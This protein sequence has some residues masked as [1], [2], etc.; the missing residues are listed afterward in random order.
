MPFHVFL[1]HSSAD[2]PAV[3][4]LARRFAKEGIQAWLDK[5]HLIPGNPWQ[6]DIEKALAE[7]ETCVVLVGPRGFG[8][9]QTRRCVRRSIAAFATAARSG[10]GCLPKTIYVPIVVSSAS[11]NATFIIARFADAR[12]GDS[13]FAHKAGL[14]PDPTRAQR[15]CLSVLHDFGWQLPM[16][17]L[18]LILVANAVDLTEVDGLPSHLPSC[19]ASRSRWA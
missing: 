2:K 14:G 19:S 7:S 12:P 1:S 5:W 16:P 17:A 4:E 15:V 3:E 13:V 11:F 10:T 9:W 8:P 18:R 6:P